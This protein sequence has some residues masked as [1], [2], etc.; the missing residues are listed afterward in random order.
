MSA[1]AARGVT[2][3]GYRT[4]HGI[5]SFTHRT[6]TGID[7]EL[8]TPRAVAPGAA[9]ILMVHGFAGGRDDW[10][11][12]VRMV[13]TRACRPVLVYD[14]RGVGASADEPGPYSVRQLSD[15]ARSVA[16]AAGA[17]RVAVLGISL[18]S[19][20]AQ[21]FALE[22]PGA[23]AALILGCASHGGRDAVQP[24]P[25]FFAKCVELA[26]HPR[27]NESEAMLEFI[28]HGLPP[29]AWDHGG[30]EQLLARTHASYTRTKRTSAGLQGQLAAMGQ[31]NSTRRLGEVRCP[32]L[33]VTGDADAVM[34]PVN[35]ES[36]VRRVAGAQ[37]EVHRGA[38]HAFWAHEPIALVRRLARFLEGV[39]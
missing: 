14:Q 19:M 15:D 1:R 7:Y 33:V 31:F 21:S 23:A 26:A 12:L 28:R 11:P 35:S 17:P 9:P 8:Y 3:R 39:D 13:G 25:L 30:G 18:G 2:R 24:P 34:P 22:Y 29:A 38:G 5:T 20:V 36:I 27:P 6:A 16:E 10:G 37:L 32:T 4:R